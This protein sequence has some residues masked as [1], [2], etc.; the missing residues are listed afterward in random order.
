MDYGSHWTI[1]FCGCLI[2]VSIVFYFYFK[3]LAL[4][5]RHEDRNQ[6]C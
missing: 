3:E 1:L 4:S 6:S 2:V 5:Q